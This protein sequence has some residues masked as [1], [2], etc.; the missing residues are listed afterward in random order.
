MNHEACVCYA[1][2][3]IFKKGTLARCFSLIVWCVHCGNDLTHVCAV[4]GNRQ[5]KRPAQARPRRGSGCAWW[6]LYHPCNVHWRRAVLRQWVPHAMCA[7]W[8]A[9]FVQRTLLHLIPI[10]QGSFFYLTPIVQRLAPIYT[11]V[12]NSSSFEPRFI[13]PETKCLFCCMKN[14]AFSVL[15]I[16]T[17]KDDMPRMQVAHMIWLTMWCV[18]AVHNNRAIP[19]G[20]GGFHKVC[21]GSVFLIMRYERFKNHL[22]HVGNANLSCWNHHALDHCPRIFMIFGDPFLCEPCLEQ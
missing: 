19:C 9:C 12:L 7:I 2:G 18:L 20:W 15:H 8:I 16:P 10:A 11:N 21:M 5:Q 6:R 13:P 4:D 14:Y 3:V 17:D 22:T 1:R